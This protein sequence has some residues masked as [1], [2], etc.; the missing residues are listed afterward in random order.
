LAFKNASLLQ[1]ICVLSPASPAPFP[2]VPHQPEVMTKGYHTSQHLSR[3]FVVG[4]VFRLVVHIARTLVCARIARDGPSV[5]ERVFRAV[6]EEF[7]P[8]SENREER[9]DTKKK[10][11]DG[12]ARSDFVTRFGSGP[13]PS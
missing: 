13:G 10:P 7:H 2:A 9:K 4:V 11:D 5:W 6:P 3:F 1:P 8:L 12:E